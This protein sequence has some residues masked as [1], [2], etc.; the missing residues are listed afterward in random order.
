MF[1]KKN[2]YAPP[3]TFI[4]TLLSLTVLVYVTGTQVSGPETECLEGLMGDRRISLER[5]NTIDFMGELGAGGARNGKGCKYW[6][7]CL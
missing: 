1:L 4:H 7:K 2:S 6:E 3:L 5:G